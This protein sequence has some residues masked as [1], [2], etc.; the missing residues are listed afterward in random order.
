[1]RLFRR[2]RGYQYPHADMTPDDRVAEAERQARAATA[3]RREWEQR[4]RQ[5]A[6]HIAELEEQISLLEAEVDGTRE[7]QR[8]REEE[9]AELLANA[10]KLVCELQG[11]WWMRAATAANNIIDIGQRSAL[12]R[13]F[14]VVEDQ[15][16]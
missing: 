10:A 5:D 12:L 16:A 1:M 11:A 8:A 4:A 3:A 15:P 2:D 6:A 7:A 13:G 14:K 9:Y